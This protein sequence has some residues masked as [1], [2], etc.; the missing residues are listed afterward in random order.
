MF[1]GLNN[2]KEETHVEIKVYAKSWS[3]IRVWTTAGQK[4]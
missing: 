4:L 1:T 3:L 2:L